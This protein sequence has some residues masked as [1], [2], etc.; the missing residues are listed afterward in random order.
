M[1]WIKRRWT[2]READVWTKEDFITFIISPLIY[3][4]LALGVVWSLLL[5]WY[6]WIVLGL[7][8]VLLLA[9]I[10]LIDPKL[11]AISKE[12]EKKQKKYLENLEKIERWEE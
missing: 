10:W 12:Y 2:A 1:G 4:L 9:M 5:L 8:L 7:C 6:G 11:K 3:F